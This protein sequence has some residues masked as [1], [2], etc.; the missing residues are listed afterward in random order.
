MHDPVDALQRAVDELGVADVALDELRTLRKR[1]RPAVANEAFVHLA[2]DA[3]ED[4]DVVPELQE[5]GNE[6]G[7]DEPGTAGHEGLHTDVQPP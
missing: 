6:M 3:V 7:A 4:D 1:D 2:L 5:P